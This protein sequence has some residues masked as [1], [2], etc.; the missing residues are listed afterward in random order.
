MPIPFVQEC[1]ESMGYAY[2]ARGAIVAAIER[3]QG[4]ANDQTWE[5]TPA[6][7]WMT[8]LDGHLRDALASLGGPLD[9]AAS[10]CRA[11]ARELQ[12]Q[13]IERANAPTGG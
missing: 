9:D 6:E 4:L 1:K 7:T 13:S 3:I 10:D 2:T 5:G 8:D 11:Y 12:A